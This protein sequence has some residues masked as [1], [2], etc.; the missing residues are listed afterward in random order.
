MDVLIDAFCIHLSPFAPFTEK[1]AVTG[2]IGHFRVRE[3]H[4]AKAACAKG[5]NPTDAQHHPEGQCQTILVT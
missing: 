4:A 1:Q 3:N 5:C 2:Q